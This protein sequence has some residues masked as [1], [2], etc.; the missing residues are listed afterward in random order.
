MKVKEREWERGEGKG[1]NRGEREK[2]VESK[3]GGRRE[4]LRESTG[5]EGNGRGGGRGKGKEEESG[6]RRIR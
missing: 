3:K 6:V 1:L 5:G 4:E 2:G